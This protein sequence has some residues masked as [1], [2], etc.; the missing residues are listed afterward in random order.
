MMSSRYI[1][2]HE[3]VNRES[4]IDDYR[5]SPI[6]SLEVS[7][8]HLVKVIDNL[9]SA[10]AIAKERCKKLSDGLNKD[11]SAAIYLYT[12]EFAPQSVYAIVN[13]YLRTNNSIAA[14]PWYSYIKLLCTALKNLPSFTGAVWRGVYGDVA[15]QYKKGTTVC[16][17]SFTSCTKSLTIIQNFLPT[18]GKG[19]IF[20]IEC[21]NGKAISAYSEHHIEDEVLLLPGIKLLAVDDGLQI[22]G[23]RVVH[24]KEVIT[25]PQRA[26]SAQA[27]SSH[28]SGLL[29]PKVIPSHFDKTPIHKKPAADGLTSPPKSLS[30]TKSVPGKCCDP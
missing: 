19:T 13:Q 14:Q 24:L 3:P 23:M 7:T 6:V 21:L 25:K 16:W 18:S 2:K 17:W 9:A 4:G 15:Q 20:M 30:K 29:T 5:H 1:E 28:N 8:T 10:V 11:Q 27:S 22:H 26:S 12:M